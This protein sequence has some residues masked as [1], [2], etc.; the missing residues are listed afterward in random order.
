MSNKEQ[1]K[2][3]G[4]N[5]FYKF[6]RFFVDSENRLLLCDGKEV[7][8]TSKVFDILL[9]FI[10]N[11]GRL[12]TKEELMEKVWQDRFVEE[13]NLARNVSTLRKALGEDAKTHKYIIT[14]PGR[15]YRFVAELKPSQGYIAA[16]RS[17]TEITIEHE[18]DDGNNALI[19]KEKI[20]LTKKS[21]VPNNAIVLLALIVLLLPVSILIY[22]FFLQTNSPQT[23]TSLKFGEMKLTRLKYTDTVFGYGGFISPDGKS[24][25]YMTWANDKAGLVLQDIATGLVTELVAPK[26]KIT[27]WGFCF[28]PDSQQVYYVITDELRIKGQL[29]RVSIFGGESEFI[30]D[31]ISG[32]AVSPDGNKVAFLRH[33]S[34]T[35]SLIVHNLT[36]G[37]EQTL[38]RMDPSSFY[39]SLD[40]SPDGKS[41]MYAFYQHQAEKDSWYV[42]EL[43]CCET[44][45]PEEK[46]IVPHRLTK[47]LAAL[48]LPDKNG[49]IMNAIDPA[50][51]VPQI[52]HVDYPNGEI[53]RIT[54][55][56]TV[57]QGFSIS[58]D[59][60]KLLAQQIN[61]N[62]RL[63]F[64][65]E[66][67]VN[68]AQP[69]PAVFG[70]DFRGL[71]WTHDGQ[72]IFAASDGKSW[73][74]W[75]SL[76]DGNTRQQLT[77]GTGQNY[78]PTI[79]PDGKTIVFVSRRSG[80][81]QL[82]RMNA[83]GSNPE[84]LTTMPAHV[85]DP[86]FTP[87]GKFIFFTHN[88]LG[89]PRLWKISATGS[90]AQQVM[91]T[92]VSHWAISPDGEKLAYSYHDEKNNKSFLVVRKF[93]E[94]TI[95]QTFETDPNRFL[96]WTFDGSGLIYVSTENGKEN[97]WL[98]PIDGSKS[99]QLTNF[100][101]DYVLSFARAKDGKDLV[102]INS[103]V[104]F[105]VLLF[106]H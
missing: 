101:T 29:R 89:K 74:I 48:W 18:T 43:P 56:L 47:I 42:A 39:M 53:K 19:E 12:L 87:D 71:E 61:V 59:G 11:R 81:P 68:N 36:N 25:T 35:L 73:N 103:D 62:A 26:S 44:E 105:D 55:D 40:W 10:E 57:Y 94:P 34:G 102:F 45:K 80:S 66:G 72:I 69:L 64:A 98:Q 4:T 41:I 5:S 15:G 2:T 100:K 28:S 17:V 104:N 92:I 52:W 90:D 24:F 79:S 13:G 30:A 88:L 63:W 50:T 75:K 3:K 99:R 54:N 91:E 33:V 16:H 77:T 20:I 65:P 1:L 70:N 31:N 85:D 7:Q 23:N 8:L 83:D 22:R 106:T 67:D 97:V 76:P 82:W 21:F 9:I 14:V 32:C 60:K 58:S 37:N 96:R 27:Y 49:L 51:G 84:Q 38:N 78:S 46:I 93:D 95:L 86:Q 6:D